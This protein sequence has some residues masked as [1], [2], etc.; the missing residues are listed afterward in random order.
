MR[1][2]SPEGRALDLRRSLPGFPATRTRVM[3]LVAG[4]ALLCALGSATCP[5]PAAILLTLLYGAVVSV[6]LRCPLR[7]AIPASGLAALAFAV[8]QLRMTGG[9]GDQQALLGGLLIA[10]G[11]LAAWCSQALGSRTGASPAVR[12]HMS[13]TKPALSGRE[14]AEWALAEADRQGRLVTLGLLGV[15]A[16]AE[17]ELEPEERVEA[18]RQ[19][20]EVL[21]EGLPSRDILSDYGPSERLLVLPD[22]WAEDFRDAADQLVKAARQRLRRQVR[23]ALISFPGDGTRTGNPVDYLERALE[24]CRAGRTSVSLG[25]P[26]VRSMAPNAGGEHLIGAPAG[27]E[28][29]AGG[30]RSSCLPY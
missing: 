9:D 16:P 24:V 2:N 25:R 4:G 27:Q 23:V 22:V 10:S 5:A 3:L 12:L 8:M 14:R 28:K 6:S 17:E 19:L 20:D 13:P 7:I 11:V 18:M 30:V 15:D 26:R 1:G 29:E 21:G